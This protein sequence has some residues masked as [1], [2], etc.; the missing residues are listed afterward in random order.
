MASMLE[1]DHND[2]DEDQRHMHIASVLDGMDEEEA[3]DNNEDQGSQ[4]SAVF[5][6]KMLVWDSVAGGIIGKGGKNISDLQAQSNSH[7][8]VSQAND[9][10]PGTNDRAILLTGPVHSVIIVQELI[11]NIVAIFAK[12]RESRGGNF[13]P[14][15]NQG[16]DVIVGKVL[17]PNEAAGVIIGRAGAN[18]KTIQEESGA[19]V[20][21][22]PK[23]ELETKISKERVLTISGI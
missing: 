16:S 2:I 20:Q 8:K 19:R 9:F 4:N 14:P 13:P 12:P 10:Y 23:E 7:I 6:L 3:G 5:Q 18:I 1:S 21:I 11:W 15:L 22:N 17:I